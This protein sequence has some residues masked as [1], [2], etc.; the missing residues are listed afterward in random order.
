MTLGEFLFWT[1]LI[2]LLLV[3]LQ[4]VRIFSKISLAY[5]PMILFAWALLIQ[6]LIIAFVPVDNIIVDL[7]GAFIDLFLIGWL[8]KEWHIFQAHPLLAWILG[9]CM[10]VFYILEAVLR[11]TGLI[12]ILWF[13]IATYFIIALLA[14]ELMNQ[15]VINS[16]QPLLRDPVFIFSIALLFYNVFSGLLDL[17]MLI[18][19]YSGPDMVFKAFYFSMTLGIFTH[20]IYLRSFLCIPQKT[21]YSYN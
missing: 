1:Y 9:I 3:A 2:T 6:S 13:D 15:R 7:V 14:I 5:R 20:I 17:F 4:G 8:A 21:I 16:R 10:V 19:Q 12:E 18:G 11:P